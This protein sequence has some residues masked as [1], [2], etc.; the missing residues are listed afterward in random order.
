MKKQGGWIEIDFAPL[1]WGAALVGAVVGITAWT[2]V[3]LA[4]PYIK[5]FIHAA[6]A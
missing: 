6:T 2:L 3:D 1:F 5:A 4:W